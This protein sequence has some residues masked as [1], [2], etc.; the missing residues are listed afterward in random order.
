M[1]VLQTTQ[2]VLTWASGSVQSV[3]WTSCFWGAYFYTFSVSGVLFQPAA[4]RDCL[5]V[6]RH[7]RCA[8]KTHFP[9][10]EAHLVCLELCEAQ[11]IPQHVGMIRRFASEVT[12][13]LRQNTSCPCSAYPK[14]QCCHYLKAVFASLCNTNTSTKQDFSNQTNIHF[15]SIKLWKEEVNCSANVAR[16]V[17]CLQPELPWLPLVWERRSPC[18][19]KDFCRTFQ[20]RESK[21]ETHQLYLEV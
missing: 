3:Q 4:G 7:T 2:A 19:S 15:K 8:P 9:L 21:T 20:L 1:I 11:A 12:P 14:A 10:K 18:Y 17:Q 6:P 16:A 13:D 5:L